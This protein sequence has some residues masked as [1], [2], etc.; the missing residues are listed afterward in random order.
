MS[1]FH[2]D[3]L[4][5]DN[6]KLKQ[7]KLPFIW[8]RGKAQRD[9]K[10]LE[11][12]NHVDIGTRITQGWQMNKKSIHGLYNRIETEHKLLKEFYVS[13]QPKTRPIFNM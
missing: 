1:H 10:L 8:I 5:R 4:F 3:V 12:H 11:R 9:M 2:W 13:A 6:I 7:T